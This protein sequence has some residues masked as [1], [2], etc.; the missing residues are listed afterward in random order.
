MDSYMNFL[1]DYANLNIRNI[2]EVEYDRIKTMAY[3]VCDYLIDSRLI[4][5]NVRDKSAAF[6]FDYIVKHNGIRGMRSDGA[7]DLLV[8]STRES[9]ITLE[10][11]MSEEIKKEEIAKKKM[12]GNTD[13]QNVKHE[14]ISIQ[15]YLTRKLN[16][17]YNTGVLRKDID[18][19]ELTQSVI[20]IYLESDITP[21]DVAR[22]IYDKNLALILANGNNF[23]DDFYKVKV[24]VFDSNSRAEKSITSA[25][26]DS[27]EREMRK[28][29]ITTIL[30]EHGV[31]MSN[32]ER[33]KCDKVVSSYLDREYNRYRSIREQKEKR[34]KAIRR[35][36]RNSEEDRIKRLVAALAALGYLAIMGGKAYNAYQEKQEED[37][38]RKVREY[39]TS[40]SVTK[41]NFHDVHNANGFYDYDN[42]EFVI[43]ESEYGRSV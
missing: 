22:G 30:M 17:F 1:A 42:N 41:S 8:K 37:R 2:D 4:S 5:G 29:E 43:G 34:E 25:Y 40:Q 39:K 7:L 33:D 10:K 9:G 28:N 12:E 3:K 31:N 35:S 6:A 27:E 11:Q 26:S 14:V 21:Q 32:I 15:E 16:R 36:E 20:D 18:L 24:G 19:R 38:L 23:S 13:S